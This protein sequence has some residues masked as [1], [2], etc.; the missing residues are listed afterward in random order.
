M[1][2]CISLSLAGLISVKGQPADE[3]SL[4]AYLGALTPTA[5]PCP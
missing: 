4:R 5:A 3:A 1:A 2:A